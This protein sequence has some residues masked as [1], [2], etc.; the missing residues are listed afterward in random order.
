M[1][2]DYKTCG[3]FK[4]FTNN[5]NNIGSWNKIKCE[6]TC[7]WYVGGVASPLFSEGLAN[8]ACLKFYVCSFLA[9]SFKLTL[10]PKL[11]QNGPVHQEATF[12]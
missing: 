8:T 11:S 9:N 4:H 12:K 7:V 10:S 2:F 3:K 5:L 1:S 6:V